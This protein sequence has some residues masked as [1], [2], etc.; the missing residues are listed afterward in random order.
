MNDNK[1]TVKVA[2]I[3]GDARQLFLAEHL[4]E[5]G[6]TV[7]TFQIDDN[8][9]GVSKCKSPGDIA[10]CSA[11]ILPVKPKDNIDIHI[12][13]IDAVPGAVLFAWDPEDASLENAAAHGWTVCDL[14]TDETLTVKN[15]QITAEAA[16]SIFMTETKISVLASRILVL[17]SGRVAKCVCRSFS[18]LG[19]NAT[20]MARSDG[21]L[22]WAQ[23]SHWNTVDIRDDTARLRAY[24]SGYD[25]IINTIPRRIITGCTLDAIPENTLL[26]DLASAPFGF[27]TEEARS[28]GINAHRASALPGK[29]APESAAALIAECVVRRL[30]GGAL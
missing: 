28:R 10:L 14:A 2:V 4:A 1:K 21:E 7:H 18:A 9:P 27:D 26:I 30:E 12:C 6:Y 25:A 19:A 24:A 16:L 29:Y 8:I 3:G 5:D 20:M 11:V 17:G 22:A 23:L 13:G 15:A